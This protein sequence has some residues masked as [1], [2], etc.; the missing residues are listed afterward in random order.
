M[1]NLISILLSLAILPIVNAAE[2]K[3]PGTKSSN[4]DQILKSSVE[5][6]DH[7]PTPYTDEF[8]DAVKYLHQVAERRGWT[9]PHHKAYLVPG[10]DM[11]GM[12]VS[13]GPAIPHALEAIQLIKQLNSGSGS[14]L[15]FA[16]M[17]AIAGECSTCRAFFKKDLTLIDNVPIVAHVLGHNYHFAT[18]EFHKI[19]PA[20]VVHA[21]QKLAETMSQYYEQLDHDTVSLFYQYLMSFEMDAMDPTGQ[22]D[23]PEKLDPTV[24]FNIDRN[25]PSRRPSIQSGLYGDAETQTAQASGS[26]LG[27]ALPWKHTYSPLQALIHFLP[28]HAEPWQREIV[29]LYELRKRIYPGN[30][31]TKFKNEGIATFSMFHLL[32]DTKW[33][34]HPELIQFAQLIGGAAVTTN[35]LGR[36]PWVNK[37]G[38][39]E[40]PLDFLMRNPYFLGPLAWE[41][42]FQKFL[43][44]GN[45]RSLSVDDQ[46]HK[47]MTEVAPKT[48]SMND[49]EFIEFALTEDWWR[50][51]PLFL[52]RPATEAEVGSSPASKVRGKGRDY[53][54]I[55]SRDRQR[56]I[57]FWTRRIQGLQYMPR[58][59]QLH[60]ALKNGGIHYVHDDIQMK[61]LM[62]GNVV[63][64][65]FAR[66][67]IYNQPVHLKTWISSAWFEQPEDDGQ[68]KSAPRSLPIEYIVSPSGKVSIECPALN[69]ETI[70]HLT[71][72]LTQTIV[73]YKEDVF[74]SFG[75]GFLG[76]GDEV[77]TLAASQIVD[78]NT[79]VA[80]NFAAYNPGAA[81][82]IADFNRMLK[83]RLAKRMKAIAKG[84]LPVT[85]NS[86]GTASIKMLP[87]IPHYSFDSRHIEASIGALPDSPLDKDGYIGEFNADDSEQVIM[88]VG[89]YLVGDLIPAP[90]PESKSKEGQG[91]SF[92]KPGPP[93]QPDEELTEL[94]IPLTTLGGI[95]ADEYGLPNPRKTKPGSITKESDVKRGGVRKPVGD[96]LFERMA[97][98]ALQ[99]ANTLR[100]KANK[101]TIQDAKT[102]SERQRIGRELIVEGFKHLDLSDY[103][104]AGKMKIQRPNHDAML[105]IGVDF[106]GSMDSQDRIKHAKQMAF[107]LQ[108]VLSHVYGSKV[109]VEFFYFQQEAK[110]ATAE[111]IFTK[112]GGGAT[113]Y[114]NAFKAAKEI[115]K[116]Y[117]YESFNRHL[118]IIGDGELIWQNES[119][120]I[121][122][123]IRELAPTLQSIGFAITNQELPADLIAVIK[124]V[125]QSY[126]WIGYAQISNDLDVL[127]AIKAI[128]PGEDA[129]PPK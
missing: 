84:Q 13:N 92:G 61:P 7:S 38:E 107:Y 4:C 43:R 42:L 22:V 121:L 45:H 126:P 128:L 55:L 17:G 26:Q 102:G 108:A 114:P 72:L 23:T 81:G 35:V 58:I 76:S 80:T 113:S 85:Q 19:A 101:P 6:V 40:E 48:Y 10:H 112:F 54:I 68:Q 12:A 41:E 47:F 8:T 122:K 88:G 115:L 49:S 65:S 27:N 95:F 123:H 129:D 29:R 59:A 44:E 18:S 11:N 34:S 119:S 31:N 62:P 70:D 96:L 56:M 93:N 111:E 15:E 86:R 97:V 5:V 124:Q 110:R 87:S 30:M 94:E 20:D 21:S 77:S 63:L 64:T 118:V 79:A 78:Q 71:K 117:P 14:V 3:N 24:H 2:Q 103:V 9:L 60:P 127:K 82:A 90:P 91:P 37:K 99:L 67:Q 74:A 100:K 75:D 98:N 116:D 39:L 106:T 50:R 32:K 109:P 57:R 36:K 25:Q 66:S 1:K 51:N 53:H 69:P 73:D 46:L 120:E 33:N 104:V 52:A 16:T 28:A 83:N 89:D 105:L 125:K